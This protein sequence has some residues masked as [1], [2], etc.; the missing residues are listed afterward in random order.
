MFL[1]CRGVVGGG[2]TVSGVL[3]ASFWGVCGLRERKVQQRWGA[4]PFDQGGQGQS[5]VGHMAL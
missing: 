4:Q 3:L 2:T 5:I 1:V